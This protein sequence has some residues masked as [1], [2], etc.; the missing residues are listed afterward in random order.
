LA[1]FT[2]I[3]HPCAWLGGGDDRVVD[4]G[5]GREGGFLEF[6]VG[7][8]TYVYVSEFADDAGWMLTGKKLGRRYGGM[9][10]KNDVEIGFVEG[11]LTKIGLLDRFLP[12]G[13]NC[14]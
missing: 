6:D 1:E 8:L 12:Y 4:C 7:G 10:D 11:D 9:G 3:D 5:G 2:K 13:L 14:S